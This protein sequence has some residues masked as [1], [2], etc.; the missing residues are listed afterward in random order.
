M[1]VAALAA[2]FLHGCAGKRDISFDHVYPQAKLTLVLVGGNSEYTGDKGLWKIRDR[3]KT[4]ITNATGFTGPEEISTL[5]FAWTGDRGDDSGFLPGHFPWLNGEKYIWEDLEQRGLLGAKAPPMVLVGWSNGGATA[6][7]LAAL[8]ENNQQRPVDLLV[9]LDPVSVL[10]PRPARSGAKNWLHVYTRS[11]G[12]KSI[13]DSGNIIAYVGGAWNKR[14]LKAASEPV[15]QECMPGN[16]GQTEYMWPDVIV[17]SLQFKEWAR[18]ISVN[19]HP[20]FDPIAVD[21]K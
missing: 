6:T 8:I 10:T 1:L 11:E 7:L 5:Y 20:K 19:E 3:I 21:C 13:T 4:D 12:F 15:Y 14:A 9:T 2:M 16:H 17:H 18:L